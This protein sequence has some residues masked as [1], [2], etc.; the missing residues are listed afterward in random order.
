M[1]KRIQRHQDRVMI[2]V[3]APVTQWRAAPMGE[4]AT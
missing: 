2:D 1:L 4:P 3:I